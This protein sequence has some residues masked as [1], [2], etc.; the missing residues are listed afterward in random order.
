MHKMQSLY[1]YEG[2]VLQWGLHIPTSPY[3]VFTMPAFDPDEKVALLGHAAEGVKRICCT[4][5][6]SCDILTLLSGDEILGGTLIDAI[7]KKYQE[8]SEIEGCTHWTGR[9]FLFRISCDNLC[10]NLTIW[11]SEIWLFEN[12][13][14]WF[15]G[16]QILGASQGLT[17]F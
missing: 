5:I 13:F 15:S 9:N 16:H 6:T 10:P 11:G 4:E 1:H 8:I 3:L 14:L 12:D 7:L 17:G 2:A